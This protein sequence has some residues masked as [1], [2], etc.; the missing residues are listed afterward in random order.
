MEKLIEISLKILFWLTVGFVVLYLPRILGWFGTLRPQKRLTNDKKSRFALLVPARNES[1]AIGDLFRSI[2]E[3]D[4]DPDFFDVHIIVKEPD[5]PTIEMAEKIGAVV[6]VVPEQTC[7]G[8]ALDGALKTILAAGEKYDAYLIIDADCA[9]APDFLSRMNDAMASGADV[10]CA[11]KLV[12]NH[13]PTKKGTSNIWTDCN[14]VIWTL[15]DDM[16]TASNP[17]TASPA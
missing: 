6:H 13:L 5:D 12:K 15:I 14:G 8:D 16:G 9:L 1:L 2:G 11:K 7:K 10:I 17:T 3:Q 4:Y